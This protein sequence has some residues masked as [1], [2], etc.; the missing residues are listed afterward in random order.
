MPSTSQ[1]LKEETENVI[2]HL[3]IKFDKFNTKIRTPERSKIN[4]SN[5]YNKQTHILNSMGLGGKIRE[6]LLGSTMAVATSYNTMEE[7]KRRR[8][9]RP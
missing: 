4:K 2:F 5:Q 3:K 9:K 1:N 6:N 7:A 8:N